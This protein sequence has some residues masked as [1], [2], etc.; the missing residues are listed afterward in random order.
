MGQVANWGRASL[1][2]VIVGN[3]ENRRVKALSDAL[4]RRPHWIV[5]VLP[6]EALLQLESANMP[7]Y[8][9]GFLDDCHQRY[10]P[11]HVFIKIESPGE[12]FFV[13][14]GLIALGVPAHD[15]SITHRAV[16]AL[17]FDKGAIRF[18]RLW[19]MGFKRVLT[20]IQQTWEQWAI[21]AGKPI[22]WSNKPTAIIR[23]FNKPELQKQLA[24]ASVETP[25][26]LFS[27]L[28]LEGIHHYQHLKSALL[29]IKVHRVFVKLKYGSSASGVVALQLKPDG[30]QVRATTSVAYRCD[31]D[32][33]RLYNCLKINH[34]RDEAEIASVLNRLI[35]EGVYVERWVPK[36]VYGEY[37][38]DVRMLIT[39]QVARHRLIRMSRSPI[40]NLHLGNRR[41]V[42]EQHVSDDAI[43]T[44]LEATALAAIGQVPGA[45]HMAPDIAL[46]SRSY[47]PVVLEINAF[48]D[49]LPGWL[50]D[51]N[52]T[53]E[54]LLNYAE[55]C[56]LEEPCFI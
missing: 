4:N 40:T 34:Y 41:G 36:S 35:E 27:D 15:A 45:N 39:G 29:S 33:I 2:M 17:T 37:S 32:Q 28:E 8:L 48:G 56:F 55:S 54:T 7:S 16:R 46:T 43:L 12:N 52:S 21:A 30:S 19:Y 23:V 50:Y 26:L 6:Y 3:P 13:E 1:L 24:Q 14:R 51:G 20:L 49:L 42:L 18:T 10:Q 11:S 25:A 44:R 22:H 53:Q 9:H 5:V 38:F 31:G 47:K